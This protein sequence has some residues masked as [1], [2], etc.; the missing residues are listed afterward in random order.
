MEQTQQTDDNFFGEEP[1][2]GHF[3]KT[4]VNGQKF[5]NQYGLVSELARTEVSTVH[6]AHVTSD[7][8]EYALKVYKKFQLK[9]QKEYK[10]RAD[11]LGMAVTDQLMKVME[12]EVGTLKHLQTL[13]LQTQGICMLHEI[14]Q[15]DEKLIL[16]LDLCEG[17]QLMRWDSKAL[18]FTPHDCERFSS[19]QIQQIIRSLF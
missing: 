13:D 9:K 8:K 18:T 2:E 1:Q 16:V 17:G 15:D 14:M 6:K 11:G 19:E 4:K 3:T 12:H 5:F 7:A 10:R